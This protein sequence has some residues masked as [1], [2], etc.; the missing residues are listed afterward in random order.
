MKITANVFAYGKLRVCVRGFSE[1]K[2]DAS[3]QATHI[4]LAKTSN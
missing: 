3:K 1:G 2:S 4:G